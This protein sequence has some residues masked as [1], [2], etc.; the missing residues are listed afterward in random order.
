LLGGLS[1][2]AF[3]RRHW[4]RKPL[5][6]RQAMPDLKPFLTPEELAGLACE[7]DV[8]SRLVIEKG[9]ARP[10]QV[11]HG[12]LSSADFRKLPRKHWTLLVT[13]VDKIVRAAG[14]LL[15]NF[16]FIPAWRVDDL[17]VSYAADQGSVGPH[18]DSYD[19]FLL[20]ADGTR[21][22]QISDRAHTAED[23]VAGLD[24]RII[25]D[26]RA[27]EE[28][29]LEPGDMLYLPP[30][31]AHYGIAEGRCM[32]YSVGFRA[33]SHRDLITAYADYVAGLID[34]EA[35]YADPDLEPQPGSGEIGA[36]ARRRFRHIVR[37]LAH[38]EARI[39]DWLGRYLTETGPWGAPVPPR[40][41][42]EPKQ[43][44]AR[45]ARRR[46]LLRNDRC[47]F[48][49][50]AEGRAC[51]LYVD[52]LAYPLPR[53]LAFAGTL[54]SGQRRF[55]YDALAEERQRRGFLDL[56]CEFHNKGYLHFP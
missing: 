15:E 38:H 25:G 49:H 39:D 53:P 36:A 8:H 2:E 24:L 33:P 28:W 51:T 11:I 9:G 16:D 54:I 7:E 13:D 46:T 29:L 55:E 56:L 44:S 14:D 37:A 32:T 42:L 45:W 50:I 43:F 18:L 23:F 40:R 17:M 52:G 4:Q 41:A 6:V 12:P 26:F 1:I 34:P 3:L 30:G 20:Q 27:S 31:V 10:W 47:R 21:R 19:V 48:A 35:R 5:L 22:W